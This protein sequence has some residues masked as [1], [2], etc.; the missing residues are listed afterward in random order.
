M[1]AS[2]RLAL[3]DEESGVGM[4]K[5]PFCFLDLCG[6]VTQSWRKAGVRNCAVAGVF[7]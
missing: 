7:E 6:F 4:R 5:L 3:S 1:F 2:L